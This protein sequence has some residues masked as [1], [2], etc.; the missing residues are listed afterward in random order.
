MQ[1]R[2]VADLNDTIYRNVPRLP[3][4]IDLV[5]GIPR[6][7]LLA[8]SLISLTLNLPLADLDGFVAGAAARHRT[9]SGLGSD[10]GEFKNVLVADDSINSGKSIG[11]ARTQTQ[12]S[13]YAGNTSPAQT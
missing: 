3:K 4:D 8:A 11:A 12:A 6:S 2:S 13:G 1:Y 10:G 9:V 5:V 7:G